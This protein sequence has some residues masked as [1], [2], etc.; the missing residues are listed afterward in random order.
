MREG[1]PCGPVI[2]TSP[3]SAESV[4]SV[5]GWG[6]KIHMPHGQNLKHK[7]EVIL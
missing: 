1:L 5:P 7:T 4:D 6:T 3:S 2:K